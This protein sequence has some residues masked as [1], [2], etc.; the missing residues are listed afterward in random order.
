MLTWTAAMGFSS[1]FMPEAEAANQYLWVSAEKPEHD[2]MFYGAQVVEIV[3][4]DPAINRLD[5]AYGMPDVTIDGSKVIMAQGVDGSWYAYVADGTYATGVDALFPEIENGGG[6]DFG[7][8]CAPSTNL[9]YA[10]NDKPVAQLI[11]TETRGVAIPHQIGNH[12]GVIGT[13]SGSSLTDGAIG[14]ATFSYTKGTGVTTTCDQ[15]QKTDG[16]QNLVSVWLNSSSV[17]HTSGTALGVNASTEAINNVV[18]E[19]RALSNGTTTDFY[20]NIALG[21]NLWPLIQIYDFSDEQTVDIVYEKG[22]ADETVQLTFDTTDGTA[23]AVVDRDHW[24]LGHEINL[25]ITD[26]QYNI[27]PT[28]EDV[29]TFAADPSTA[30]TYYALFTE[31]G[32]VDSE[33]NNTAISNDANQMSGTWGMDTGV[34]I[35]DRNGPENTDG[36]ALANNV[37]DYQDNGDQIVTDADAD[38]ST[39]TATAITT[40]G[41]DVITLTETGANTGVFT[42]WDDALKA[43]MFISKDAPRGTQATIDWNDDAQSILVMPYWGSIEYDTSEIGAEWNSGETVVINVDDGDMNFDSNQGEDMYIYSNMTI[44]PAIKI[45]SPITLKGLDTLIIEDRSA[46]DAITH[47][48][49]DLTTSSSGTQQ[50]CSSD[51]AAFGTDTSYVSCYEKYSERA[52][53]TYSGADNMVLA[54]NDELRFLY[55]TTIGELESLISGSNGT[56]GYTYIQYDFRSLNGGS[57]SSNYYLNFTVGDGSIGSSTASAST[58]S[59][60][61]SA[62]VVTSRYSTGLAGTV[63]FSA[64]ENRVQ[65]WTQMTDTDAL[66]VYVQLNAIDGSTLAHDGNGDGTS[67]ISAGQSYPMV[68]DFVTYG[69]SN[70][71][72]NSGDRHNNSIVRL[73]V[74]ET[75][76]NSGVFSAELEY[77]MLNQLNVNSSSTYNSTTVGG[78]DATMIVHNDLTDE[79]E[80]RVNY[81]DYG[82]DGVE[83]QVGAQLAAPT[84]SGVVEFDNDSYK[85]ADTVV[86]TLTDSDL[87]VDPGLI[88]IFTVVTTH[89]LQTTGTTITDDAYDQVGSPN[90]GVN[91]VGDNNGR[92][93]DIT[94]DDELW[95]DSDIANGDGVTCGGS[96]DD[97]LANSGFT[98][99]ETGANTGVFTGDFQVPAEYCARSGKASGANGAAT[100]V[101]GTDIEVNYVDYRDA[102]GEIIEVGDGAGIRGNTGSVSLDRTVYPVPF[103]VIGDFTAETTKSSPNGRALFPVHSSGISTA[104]NAS[105][106]TIGSGDLT[107]HIRVDDP[108]YDV[109]AAGEDKINENTS[110]T[111]NRGPLK[112][113]VSRGSS[114]VVLATAGADDTKYGVITLSDVVDGG[115][116][117]GTRELGPIDETAPDSGV[118]ELDMTVRYTDGPASSDCPST[119]SAWTNS[120]NG[121]TTN[122]DTVRF[123]TTAATGNY[124]I[125]QGDV[126][127][128]E[129][130]DQNDASGNQAVAYDS[131]TFDLRN[132]VLQTDKSVYIIG[133]DIIMT[134]IEPDLDLESDESETWDLDLIEWDS[135]A[136]TLT[137]G[138]NGGSASSFDPEP[139]D[140]RETGDS[141]GIFQIVIETPSELGGSTLDRGELI[142]LEYTDWSPSGADYV[143]DEYSDIPLSIY[144]SNFGATIELDQKVY[145]WTDKVYITIVAP[146]HNFDSG[147]VD[148]IGD[149]DDDPLIVQ[150]RSQK[151][152]GYKLAETGSD[153]G[154]FSGEVI[155]KGFSHDADGDASTGSTSS[156]YD[157]VGVTAASGTGPTNGILKAEDDDGLSVSYEFN[158]DEVVVGSALIRWNIGEVQWLESS[159][160]A[161]GNGVIRIVDPDMNWDPE[162]VDNFSIDVWSDSDAGGVSLTVTETNEATGI[163]E[164]TV[165]FTAD[166]ESSGSRLRVAEGDTITAEYE[167]NTLPDPYTRSDDLDVTGTALIGTL[168]PP[169]ERAPAANARVVDSFGNSLSEVSVDQQV[170]IEADLVNGQDKDQSF[171]YLVQ[172]QDGNGV[173]VSLAWIT[174]QLAAGQSFSPALSWIPSNSGSYEATVFVWESVDN[175][176]ALSDTVSVDIRVV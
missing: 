104:L 170:Q 145:T 108:D 70:D 113:Y 7:R 62:H 146:D 137:M 121:A 166:D 75:D 138:N 82:A 153:T 159:Y 135:D 106:E 26:V 134:L 164:G 80:V 14:D 10:P 117:N 79:D 90:Y 126:I 86:V 162:N 20:G 25:T 84:H 73:E 57:D 119:T 92:L 150:T 118:F 172:V 38:G 127:T 24:G 4:T 11:P 130:T 37:I 78:D 109:S 13:A 98:L 2:N 15:S 85:E 144:T 41:S 123:D 114:T 111:S 168:I 83:T 157:V 132:G 63:L 156:G 48:F 23:S 59:S 44:V 147:L 101:M 42:N 69:Q 12:S 6:A 152:T 142:D 51:Y 167:D 76:L 66:S 115:V 100:S 102:S 19:A 141:T 50:A 45:G 95:L 34:L 161:G 110:T 9:E 120:Q 56:A 87:N 1:T 125:L 155:L 107:I 105:S 40:D 143:G 65:N 140:F 5:E 47:T 43:N 149:T 68:L 32:T 35:I 174:G 27:D 36:Q 148:Q 169:L 160:P 58:S 96:V 52:I 128:V 89:A 175:P 17:G 16:T 74:S 71:G 154:I 122:V 91:S 171:A 136:H 133:S 112:I 124:C 53:L 173:T 67:T 103:G 61:N 139:S 3:V 55:T 22:G 81:L 28:D 49:D 29:W 176:T 31:N 163:F 158:E 99:V 97:G 46:S 116:T 18:R 39:I 94:F 165:T 72:V 30:T 131:A 77:I 60:V 64:P 8:W 21:P 151:L 33:T 93:L 129:Y 54:D 88:D